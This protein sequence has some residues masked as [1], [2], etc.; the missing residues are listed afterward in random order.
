MTRSA[1]GTRRMDKLVTRSDP[2]LLALHNHWTA[3]DAV[4]HHLRRSMK[5]PA[6]GEP[7]IPEAFVALGYTMSMFSVISVWYALLYVVIEGYRD[8]D[9][10][11]EHV[12]RLLDQ[13]DYVSGL[14]QFRNA[15]F[16]YQE[17]PI[18]GKVMTFLTAP[19]SE[20]WIRDL[21]R[22]F[23]RFLTREL[24]TKEDVERW[25]TLGED[26]PR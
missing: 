3:A 13:T 5:M 11:D 1:G 2:K 9:I 12:D 16:H 10:R 25:K 15:T 6:E 23:D 14:R 20:V 22:A 18:P 21:A 8:L 19:G 24:K 17:D 26:W 4:N 7:G